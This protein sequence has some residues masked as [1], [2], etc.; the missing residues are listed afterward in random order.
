M[1]R[2]TGLAPWEVEFYFPGN[3]TSTFLRPVVA[4]SG[5]HAAVVEKMLASG[6]QTGAKDEV[7]FVYSYTW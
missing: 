2:W 6:A 1:I 4:S 3:L 7:I 5:G